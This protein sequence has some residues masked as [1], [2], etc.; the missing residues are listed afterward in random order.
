MY[1]IFLERKVNNKSNFVQTEWVSL[2]KIGF[3]LSQT[4]TQKIFQQIQKIKTGPLDCGL[5]SNPTQQS[6]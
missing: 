2:E 1:F 6:Y 3:V 4:E 5:Y